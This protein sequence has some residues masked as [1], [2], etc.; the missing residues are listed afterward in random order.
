MVRL[1]KTQSTNN[2]KLYW[3]LVEL[4]NNERFQKTSW[5]KQRTLFPKT[6]KQRFLII[7]KIYLCSA[8]PLDFIDDLF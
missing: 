3:N 1:K 5:F 8:I 4:K 7:L 6:V 2:K